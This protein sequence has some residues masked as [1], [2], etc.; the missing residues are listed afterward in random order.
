MAL[1]ILQKVDFEH[2][3]KAKRTAYRLVQNYFKK[4]S[5]GKKI[6]DIRQV[7]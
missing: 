3:C 6:K 2:K 4:M 1:L 5:V 7:N